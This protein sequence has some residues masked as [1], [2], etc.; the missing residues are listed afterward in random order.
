MS[1][2]AP[3]PYVITKRDVGKAIATMVQA[4]IDDPLSSY[5][6]PEKESRFRV[7]PKFFNYRIKNG[8]LD[9]KVL[10]TSENI[11]GAVIL[12][13]SEYNGFSWLRDIRT[14]GLGFFRVAGSEVVNRMRKMESFIVGK[15][16][17]CISEPHWY[18]GSL[19]VHPDYQG[20]G[21]A[22]KLV[23]P[24]LE[25]CSSQNIDCVLETQDED[26]VLIYKHYGFEVVDSFT[27]PLAKLPHWVMIKHP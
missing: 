8:L 12:T 26:L 7:L 23:R 13:Q 14:G 19:A 20:K 11:E 1:E 24:V 27:L 6:V 2:S 4:F 9:G 22:S 15:R 5:F 25:M 16:R 18:L 21:F 17:E 10:A 3:V